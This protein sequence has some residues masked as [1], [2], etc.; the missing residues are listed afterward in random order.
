MS[1]THIENGD[2]FA[3]GAEAVVNTV[4]CVGVMGKGLA[5][6][7]KE[8]FPENFAAYKL[9]CDGRRLSPGGLFP[10]DQGAV[11]GDDGPKWIVNLA[12]K[13]HWRDPSQLS[14]V[15]DG[16]QT[17]ARWA[18]DFQVKSIACP[19]LGAGLGGLPW[20]DVKAA[21]EHAFKDSQ[22]ELLLFAPQGPAPAPRR[23]GPR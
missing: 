18:K 4:N 8:R 3:S 19:A 23:F 5:L 13:G 15:E 20:E 6:T 2:L 21:V 22:T 14:W 1:V 9:E 11:S 10:F 17:L 16:A 12:T 7:F